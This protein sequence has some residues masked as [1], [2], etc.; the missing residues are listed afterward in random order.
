MPL[1]L[2]AH[3]HGMVAGEIQEALGMAGSTLSDHLEKLKHEELVRVRR[4]G[5]LL[6][7][8]ANCR[9]SCAW[10]AGLETRP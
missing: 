10:S 5:A 7:Y 4:E 6:W 2:S 9:H 3:P 8:S 1:L